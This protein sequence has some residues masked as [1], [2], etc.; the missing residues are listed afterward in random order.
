[1]VKKTFKNLLLQN[2]RA[3]DLVTWYVALGTKGWCEGDSWTYIWNF[4]KMFVFHPI[5]NFV[6][7]SGHNLINLEVKYIFSKQIL[8]FELVLTFDW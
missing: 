4:N 2:Q 5:W 8:F 6:C 1:M 7:I 3:S